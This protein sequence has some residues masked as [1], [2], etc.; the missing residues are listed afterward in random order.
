LARRFPILAGPLAEGFGLVF[1]CGGNSWIDMDG[2]SVAWV[3]RWSEGLDESR[4]RAPNGQR[5]VVDQAFLQSKL[6]HLERTLIVEV[7][8]HREV[9]PFEYEGRSEDAE[10]DHST[11]IITLGASG[12]PNFVGINTRP[13]RKARRRTK[14]R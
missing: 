8:C 10:E 3:E 7:V 12:R 4:E 9:V 2:R 5:L 14:A 1:D 13:R 6:K 11:S